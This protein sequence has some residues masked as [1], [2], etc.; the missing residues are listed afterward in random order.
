M[1]RACGS[2]FGEV[3]GTRWRACG[4]KFDEV[5]GSEWRAVSGGH[6]LVSLIKRR[7]E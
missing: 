6:A 1:E 2:K 4:S 5:E 7:A 3:E